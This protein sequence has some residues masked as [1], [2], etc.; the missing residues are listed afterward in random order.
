MACT[1]SLRSVDDVTIVDLAG[2]VTLGDSSCALRQTVRDL[3]QQG[4]RRILLNLRDVTYIDSAGMGELVS[5]Y[6]AMTHR[7]G[8]IKLLHAANKVQDVL[9]ATRLSLV[10][11]NFNDEAEAL[12]SFARRATA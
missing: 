12:R 6:A 3:I 9:R 1:T 11:E 8:E 5:S 2:R 10:F 7:G 4:E